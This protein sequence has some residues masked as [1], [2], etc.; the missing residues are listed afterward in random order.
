MSQYL[1][2][3]SFEK[4][5]SITKLRCS[6][7]A[8]AIEKGRHNKLPRETRTCK[9]CINGSVENEEHFLFDC[10][11]YNDI[12]VITNFS[13]TPDTLFEIDTLE[14]LGDY[15]MHALD[16]RRDKELLN[17]LFTNAILLYTE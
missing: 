13:S 12:R 5:K 7:H 4:R 10:K 16:K 15:I 3:N 6:D 8:L 9:V 17:N 1:N 14:L 2:I 11:F